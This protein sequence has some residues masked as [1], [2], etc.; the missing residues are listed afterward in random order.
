[1]FFFAD[2]AKLLKFR[3]IPQNVAHFANSANYAELA[4]LAKPAAKSSR[5]GWHLGCFAKPK[6]ESMQFS[7]VEWNVGSFARSAR[8]RAAA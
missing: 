3:S 4:T 7:G 1:M 8:I 6:E 2:F 5:I